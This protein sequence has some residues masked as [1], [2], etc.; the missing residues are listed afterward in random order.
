MDAKLKSHF[1]TTGKENG[2][3]VMKRM[4]WVMIALFLSLFCNAPTSADESTLVWSTFL[5][6]FNSWDE[7]RDIVVDSTGAVYVTG[8]TESMS[9]PTTSGA[10]DTTQNGSWDV[11]VAKF[12][13]TGSTLMYST[14]IGGSSEDIGCAI[15]M[16]PSGRVSVTGYS[17]SHNF[18]T[19]SGAFDTTYNGSG[20][21]RDIFITTLNM[22]GSALE[23]SSYL[24][25]AEDDYA[26]EMVI[27]NL[28][29]TYITGCTWSEDFPTTSGAVDETYHGRGDAFITKLQSQGHELEYSTFLGGSDYD[30]GYGIAVDGEGNAYVM[31]HT[32]SFDFLTTPGALD[33]SLD[34]D[35]DAFVVRLNPMGS[36]LGYSTYL[37][38]SAADGGGFFC[39]GGIVVDS[40]HCAYVTGWTASD[41][42]P[43]TAGAYDETHNGLFDVFVTKL[44]PEG[45][46]LMS[47]TYLGGDDD[48]SANG[49]EIDGFRNIYVAGYT[50]SS[51]FPT[52]P[53]AYDSTWSADDVFIAQLDP[54]GSDLECATL[55][56]GSA[57]DRGNCIALDISSNVYVTGWTES[58]DFPTTPGAFDTSYSLVDVFLAKLHLGELVPVPATVPPDPLPQRCV[59]NQNYPNP[60]NA[61]TRIRYRTPQEGQVTLEVFNILGQE[62]RCLVRADQPAGEHT[63]VWDGRDDDG[64]GL[65]SGIYFGRLQ[66]GNFGKTVKMVYLR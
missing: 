28:G 55:L 47:S 27:D 62:V 58:F 36:D 40:V 31:G 46:D 19:T 1:L 30:L 52:T 34:G 65:P 13:P 57:R 7:G 56:G 41:D 18:P 14:L 33:T 44:N 50:E 20:W 5:G 53:G 17:D 61:S 42:F 3:D 39:N 23:Y 48:D 59:L 12:D 35:S 16:G 4:V 29:N 25:G 63:V 10:F 54:E 6:V 66:A 45:T 38:G 15:A 11:F 26:E 49:I 43:V 22:E 64:R 37:G 24:G 51:N 2:M 9:F 32:R 8:Y 60:F 21:K